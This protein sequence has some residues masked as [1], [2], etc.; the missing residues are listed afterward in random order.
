[1]DHHVAY[2]IGAAYAQLGQPTEA[3]KWL[4]RAARTGFPCYQW[5]QWDPLLK[6]LRTDPGFQQLM[7]EL[8]SERDAA[9]RRYGS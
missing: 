5:F 6:P 1:M 8:R 2:S 3:Q 4:E 7:G 9:K